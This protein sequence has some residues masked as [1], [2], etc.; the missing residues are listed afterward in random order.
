MFRT[1]AFA[2]IAMVIL[3]VFIIAMILGGAFN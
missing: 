1:Q 2:T 3:L